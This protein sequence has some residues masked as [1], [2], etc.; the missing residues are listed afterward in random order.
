MVTKTGVVHAKWRLPDWPGY[1]FLV[2][3]PG[4]VGFGN[5]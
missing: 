3:D 2:H 4:G 1:D 5:I